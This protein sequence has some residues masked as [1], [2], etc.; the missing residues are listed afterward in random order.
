MAESNNLRSHRAYG[1]QHAEGGDDA[2]RSGGSDPLA[3]LARL[4]GQSDPFSET[5][6]NR[7]AEPQRAGAP[8]QSWSAEPAAQ[9]QAAHPGYQAD[10]DAAYA[11]QAHGH[12]PDQAQGYQGHEA[13][14]Y[15]AEGYPGDTYQQ[16]HDPYYDHYYDPDG[17]ALDEAEYQ[18]QQ[19][20]SRQRRRLAA[21]V[22]ILTLA[23]VGSA[24]AYGYRT[25]VAPAEH[26]SPPRVIRAD[27]GPTKIIPVKQADAGANKLIYDRVGAS[28][29]AEKVVPREEKPVDIKTAAIAQPPRIAYP[30]S[31]ANVV[32]VQTRPATIPVTQKPAGQV[33][34]V[35]S[36]SAA[37][38]EGTGAILPSA[39]KVRTVTIRP[40]M[41]V[42]PSTTM[43]EPPQPAAPTRSVIPSNA[44]TATAQPKS[45]P[46]KPPVAVAPAP[47][48]KPVAAAAPRPEPTPPRAEPV[49]PPAP[50]RHAA[51]APLSL[52]PNDMSPAPNAAP[53]P[54]QAPR[55]QAV[56]SIPQQAASGGYVVQVASQRS[57]ADANA[58]YR[59]LQG[60]YPNVLGGRSSF[61]R[62][63][64]LGSR[65][66]YYRTMV[67][68]FAS[69]EQ[70][71]QFCSA[72]KAA[73]GQCII[74]RN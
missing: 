8:A 22:A 33:L 14:G 67:G 54:S 12:Q 39:K 69:A 64:D 16:G 74:H 48:P 60:R 41:T 65:G 66:V 68:P 45:A 72:L 1:P 17:N 31:S 6:R 49:A 18:E 63:A 35:A 71:G 55:N 58:S 50:P 46:A 43:A 11:A 29:Q 27:A 19:E 34:P 9:G 47:A 38:P 4:I 21:V 42:V 7:A 73:G 52:S 70:A 13:Q 62:K 24:A 26:A 28:N 36:D 30:G 23:V 20:R 61:V 51:N 37:A 32:T 3:E 53:R 10:N 2:Y 40:D 57:E 25:F 44:T 59:T 15:Q 56:A 5:E